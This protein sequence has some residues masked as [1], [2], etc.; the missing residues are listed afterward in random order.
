MNLSKKLI[1][2]KEDVE[3]S[4]NELMRLE[5]KKEELGKMLDKELNKYKIDKK[6]VKKFLEDLKIKIEN[7]ENEI[8]EELEELEGLL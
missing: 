8:E 4:K 1:Q 3:Q 6:N 2:L 5:G 7:T